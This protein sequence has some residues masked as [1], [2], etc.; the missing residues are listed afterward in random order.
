MKNDIFENMSVPKAYM[1]LAVPVVLSMMVSLVYNMVDTY[2]IAMTGNTDLVAGIS[3]TAPVFMLMIAFGD[4]WGLGGSSLIS[5]LL[6]EKKYEEARKISSFAF[7]AA[8][9]FGVFVSVTMLLLRTQILKVLGADAATW[10][11]AGDYYTWIVIGATSIIL[12]LVP[13]N[14]LRTE[15]LAGAA[16]VGSILGSVVNIVLDPICIFSLNLG[17]A[18]AAIATVVGNVVADAYYVYVILK[19]SERLSVSLSDLNIPKGAFTGILTIGIP[20][21]ITNIMQSCMMIITNNYLLA[22]GNDKIAAMGIALKVNTISILVLVGFAFG[23]Q[24]LIGYCYG[25]KNRERLT[26]AMRFAYTLEASISVAFTAVMI[27]FAPQIIRVFMDDPSIVENGALML[28][29]LQS[30]LI[31]MSV[32]MVSTCICQ[33]FGKALGAFV[34]SISRQGVVYVIV[35]ILLSGIFGYLG[36]LCSQAV[37]DVITAVIAVI[38]V[39]RFDI[40]NMG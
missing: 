32:V 7:W 27:I 29:C 3:L 24:P 10:K 18:G 16:M 12:G 11:Y 1:T 31:F 25:A 38:I 19:K 33:S 28:R 21:S 9:A 6:G 36:I 30:S 22:Y 17:A 5:R 26:Q 13:S 4:I 40:G 20:A 34:L 37:A 35:I 8:I 2:F 23:G 14:I 15:G 39:R